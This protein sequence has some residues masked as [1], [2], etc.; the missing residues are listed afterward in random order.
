MAGFGTWTPEALN[1]NKT[2]TSADLVTLV[3]R[4]A[5]HACLEQLEKF[6]VYVIPGQM[7]QYPDEEIAKHHMSD[8][9]RLYMVYLTKKV[10]GYGFKIFRVI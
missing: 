1:A 2:R 6:T 4:A 5:E 8:K 7:K 3:Q 10:N 9:S